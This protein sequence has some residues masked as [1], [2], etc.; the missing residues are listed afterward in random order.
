MQSRNH[1]RFSRMVLTS[2]HG[3][4]VHIVVIISHSGRILAAIVIL[5][6][7]TSE[8]YQ[9]SYP[10]KNM[11]LETECNYNWR[12]L[13]AFVSRFCSGKWLAYT[14]KVSISYIS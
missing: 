9:T 14:F 13:I 11:L 10:K 3:K 12:I 8:Y 4:L 5:C 1:G 6:G 7:S 2:I